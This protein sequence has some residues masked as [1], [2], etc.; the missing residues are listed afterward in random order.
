MAELTHTHDPD[1]CCARSLSKAL[2]DGKLEG[3]LSWTHEK[4]GCE[5]IAEEIP[6]TG[7]LHWR[8]NPLIA[9]LKVRT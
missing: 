9:V 1:D 8:A 3:K 2:R 6:G 4:C 7:F 5:W